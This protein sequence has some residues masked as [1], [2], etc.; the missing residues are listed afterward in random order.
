MC[1]AAHGSPTCSNGN[2]TIAC[3]APYDDCDDNVDTGCEMNT[4]TNTSNCGQCGYV[5]GNAH[6]TASCNVGVCGITSCE[7]GYANCDNVAANGCEIHTASGDV[8]NCGSCG[9]KCSTNHGTTRAAVA[10][11]A[12]SCARTAIAIATTA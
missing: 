6:G 5:C 1:S 10:A 2:C 11:P 4:N 3:A 7:T 12:P 8:N 9:A